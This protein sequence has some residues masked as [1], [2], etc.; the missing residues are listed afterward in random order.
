[1]RVGENIQ[2]YSFLWFLRFLTI[3][4]NKIIQTLILS[5]NILLK[6]H[7]FSL[8]VALCCIIHSNT[9]RDVVF[10]YA[11]VIIVL[12]VKDIVSSKYAQLIDR[13]ILIQKD[14]DLDRND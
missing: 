8:H 9:G 4:K 13:F 11:M 14:L 10:L 2:I 1:M 12:R 5:S 6:S 3:R 7:S